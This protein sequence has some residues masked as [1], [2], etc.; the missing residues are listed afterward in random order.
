MITI[1]AIPEKRMK[2]LKKDGKWKKQLKKLSDIKVKLN[3]DVT[4]ETKDPLQVLR[5][6]E[7]FR[8]FGRGFEFEDA[9]DLFDE[10]NFLEVMKVKEFSGKSK[11]R[12]VT[13]KGRIIGTGGRTKKLI[14]KYC[15]V[16]VAIYGKTISI[17]GRWDNVK[18]A[19]QAV[20]MLLEGAMHSTVYRFLEKK[21]GK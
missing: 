4:I 14:E 11:R 17:L 13:L 16:K 15:N 12:Q 5:V 10:D 18:V 21:G 19:R 2:F 6:K 9:L 20:D 3:E 1:V 8:A 7:V